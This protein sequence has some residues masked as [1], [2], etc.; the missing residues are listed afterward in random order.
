MLAAALMLDHVGLTELAAR[1]RNAI[2]QTINVDHICTRDLKGTAS[3][4]QFGESVARRIK[5]A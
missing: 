4:R 3:T 1:F 2:D 5:D